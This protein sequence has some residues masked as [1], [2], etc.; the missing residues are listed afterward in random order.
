[1]FTLHLFNGVSI[2]FILHL[3]GDIDVSPNYLKLRGFP[4]AFQNS[5]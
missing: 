2:L 5:F 4:D 1:L 3:L